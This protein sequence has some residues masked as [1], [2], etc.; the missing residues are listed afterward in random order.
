MTDLVKGVLGGAWS[1]LVGWILPTFISLQLV[2]IFIV[3]SLSGYGA[4][5]V[6]QSFDL[7]ARQGIL[8][9]IAA[10]LGIVLAA[11]KTQ[12]YAPLEGYALWPKSVNGRIMWRSLVARASAKSVGRCVSGIS[13]G[14]QQCDRVL[15][16][17]GVMP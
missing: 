15:G 2:A 9:A 8:V 11:A 3:P 16:V 7:A 5:Q 12:L 13:A 6:F 10:T 14:Q 1:I 4:I 17:P